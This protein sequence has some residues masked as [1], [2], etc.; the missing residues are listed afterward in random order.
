[1][2]IASRIRRSLNRKTV[3]LAAALLLRLF[4]TPLPAEAFD[5]IVLKDTEIKP[6]RDAIEGFK[7]AC[8]CTVQELDLS[9]TYAIDKAVKAHPDVVFAVGTPAIKN[10]PVVYALAIPS[11]TAALSQT[12]LSGVSMDV[13]PDVYLATMTA[14]FPDVKRIGVLSDPEQTGPYVEQAAASARA[15]GITLVV[16]TVANPR[17]LPKQLDGLRGKVDALWMLPDPMLVA[18]EAVNYLMLFSFQ[19]SM[20]VFSFSKKYVS[21]G[22]AAALIIDPHAMGVQAAELAKRV[23]GGAR[24]PLRPYAQGSRLMVNMKVIEKIGVKTNDAL[25]KKAEKSGAAE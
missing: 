11:E 9:D 6:Y 12:N 25:I 10:I 2:T 7:G 22:A 4:C 18:P 16:K 23:S 20:P 13:S 5:V 3:L 19:N 14:L 15:R 8:G 21:A 17:Q 1:M 24:G